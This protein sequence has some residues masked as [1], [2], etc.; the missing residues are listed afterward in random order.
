MKNKDIAKL[1]NISEATVSCALNGKPGVSEE[2]RQKVMELKH[3]A[4]PRRT[5]TIDIF[6]KSGD[7]MDERP[8]FMPLSVVMHRFATQRGYDLAISHI[9]GN[10]D[11]REHIN[12]LADSATSGILLIATEMES[13]DIEF[14]KGLNKPVVVVDSWFPSA[15]LNSVLID[16]IGGAMSAVDNLVKNGHK[17]I[18]FLDSLIFVHNCNERY[19]GFLWGLYQNNII[20][21][22]S[23]HYKI[24]STMDGAYHD[25]LDL[26]H[27]ESPLPTAFVAINDVVAMGAINALQECGYRVPEDVSVIGFDD[28]PLA[29]CFNPHLSTV[30]ISADTIGRVATLLLIDL[31]EGNT[32]ETDSCLTIRTGTQ[33]VERDSVINIL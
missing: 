28:I 14:Y 32:P 23:L 21:D 3:G 19:Q 10:S 22:E 2:T 12:Q 8:F 33:F 25:M 16:N 1:L 18:G 31:I 26:I 15:N 29:A 27:R 30:T 13:V 5:I 20:P 17:K 11:F 6:K 24:H 9:D 4:Q 7:I